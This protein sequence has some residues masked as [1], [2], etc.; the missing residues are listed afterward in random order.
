MYVYISPLLYPQYSSSKPNKTQKTYIIT[1]IFICILPEFL[2]RKNINMYIFISIQ[3]SLK[4]ACFFLLINLGLQ[5]IPIY[6][7]I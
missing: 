1:N 3:T 6:C 4:L 2:N 7:Y 5:H